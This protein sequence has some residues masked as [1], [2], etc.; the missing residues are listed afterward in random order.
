VFNKC[1]DVAGCH[2]SSPE[3]YYIVAEGIE[4]IFTRPNFFG[5]E[6]QRKKEGVGEGGVS[7][8]LWRSDAQ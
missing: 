6:S 1:V 4:R 7:Q 8:A 5:L 2:V 3:L